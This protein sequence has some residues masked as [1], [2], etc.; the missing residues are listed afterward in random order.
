MTIIDFRSL[1]SKGQKD[2]SVQ[3]PFLVWLHNIVERFIQLLIVIFVTWLGYLIFL[4]MV[5]MMWTLYLETPLGKGFVSY[6]AERA[7]SISKV[8]E[9]DFIKL[10]L[11][12][13]FIA[14]K[15]C[16]FTGA[17]CQVFFITRYFFLPRGLLS[18]IFFWGLLL[19]GLTS[20]FVGNV[21]GLDL[22][23]A[24]ILSIFPSVILS[25]YCF[26]FT[27]RL[28]PEITTMFDATAYKKMFSND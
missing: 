25:G 14:L 19:S 18:K 12:I 17:I 6:Y 13:T 24:F 28:L 3:N 1:F 23:S 26:D 5:N 21:L 7:Q 20:Y 2:P 15:T 4:Y 9:M 16:L 11:N 8:L 10:S 22:K 27:S